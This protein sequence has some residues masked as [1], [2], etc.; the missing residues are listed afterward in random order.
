MLWLIAASSRRGLG[1]ARQERLRR[2]SRR[3]FLGSGAIAV[4]TLE[5]RQLMSV[6][7]NTLAGRAATAGTVYTYETLSGKT[8]ILKST[9]K[10]LGPA[11]FDGQN[12]VETL[13]T[14]APPGGSATTISHS[15]STLNGAGWL[16]YGTTGTTQ[17]GG[18]Q[19]SNITTYSPP[20]VLLPGTMAVGTPYTEQTT[21]SEQVTTPIAV[22]SIVTR[23]TTV[24]TLQAG[25]QSVKVPAGRYKAYVVDETITNTITTTITVAGNPI[26]TTS[27]PTTNTATEYYAPSV[28]LVEIA[29]S[30]L[31]K[32]ELMSLTRQR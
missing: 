5:G 6:S 11:S 10:V 12:V 28:G 26:T 16:V 22:T 31:D 18:T 8:V 2:T 20:E 29:F 13:I 19:S 23:S 14:G 7:A 32:F 25:K 17:N 21:S 27:G 4:E 30:A 24:L 1:F 15:Y 9:Q 3:A